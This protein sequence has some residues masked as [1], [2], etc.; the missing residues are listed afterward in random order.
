MLST[1]LAKGALRM[2][3]KA[4]PPRDLGEGRRTVVVPGVEDSVVISN[5]R[6]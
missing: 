3:E 2:L 4:V 6:F 5:L 1:T